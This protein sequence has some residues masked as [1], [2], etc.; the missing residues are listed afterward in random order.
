M[1]ESVKPGVREEEENQFDVT[2]HIR[3]PGALSKGLDK[4]AKRRLLTRTDIVREAL[5]EYLAE[6]GEL[7][8]G[9]E[10]AEVAS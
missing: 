6:A 7:P 4:V 2:L 9:M 10:V 3:V 5:L 1:S 8:E